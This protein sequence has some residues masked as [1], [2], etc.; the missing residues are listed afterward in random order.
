MSFL[1]KLFGKQ[2]PIAN[3]NPNKNPDNTH[4]IYLLNIYG[5]NPSPGNYKQV[6]LEIMNGNSFLLVPTINDE[7]DQIQG[8][9]TADAEKTL[10]LT[11]VFDQDGLKVLGAFSDEKA[12]LT[13]AQKPT[14]YTAL[15]TKAIT[16]LCQH[17]GVGRIVINSGQKNMVVLE[18]NLENLK[19]ITVKKSTEIAIGTPA[20]PLD[21]QIIGK[22]IEN[23][24]KVSTIEEAYQYAQVMNNETS[25]VLGIRMSSVSEDAKTA[26]FN[27]VT[28]VLESE[29][30]DFFVD[31]MILD[32]P[33]FI[34]SVRNI[35]NS[36][37][38]SK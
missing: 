17:I 9:Q 33:D 21:R 6:V 31:I 10:Q 5:E 19:E 28:N 30:A 7:Q 1:K 38:Y 14:T 15:K 37:F 29:K 23:F 34:K 26:L 36:L 27:A 32:N 35:S 13:W 22:L 3:E 25:I 24:K 16:E 18:R 20:K 8:W 11:S 4:L 12:L 2:K